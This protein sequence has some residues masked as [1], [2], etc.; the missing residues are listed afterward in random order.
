MVVNDV[1]GWSFP[2]FHFAQTFTIT[3]CFLPQMMMMFIFKMMMMINMVKMM[4]TTLFDY[5]L[6]KIFS[7]KMTTPNLS[8]NLIKSI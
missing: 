2:L 4:M 7:Q 8:I 3:K 1:T 6:S 5:S